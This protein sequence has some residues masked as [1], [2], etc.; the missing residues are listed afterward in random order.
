MPTLHEI[1]A[2]ISNTESK[3]AEDRVRHQYLAKLAEYTQVPTLLYASCF[4]I[5]E[6][7]SPL[8]QIDR[9][10][11]QLFMSALKDIQG[12]ELD[13]IIHS[14]GGSAEAT[15]QV[16]NYLRSKFER[17]RVIVPQS[18]MSAATM[19]AC[20]ADEIIMG[21]HSS[22]GPIDPQLI[23]GKFAVAAQSIIDEF[24]L[25]Q[26]QVNNPDNNPVLWVHKLQQYP[27]GLLI[28]C[29]NQIDLAKQL[30][31]EWLYQYMFGA[32]ADAGPKAGEIAAW[33]SDA[34]HFLS[35]GRSIGFQE[36]KRRGL[37]VRQLEDDQTLQEL[38]LSV[39]HC[40]VATFQ[41]GP[42]VKIVENH[43]GKG[44]YVHFEMNE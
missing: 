2:E 3:P 41:R 44:T 42:S 7:P 36:A 35:H 8:L 24:D 12:N 39:F 17:I 1:H 43:L 26:R 33:L 4:T 22:L 15:E 16:V 18:A 34:K 32:K 9:P 6:A 31:E 19:F 5:K 25:A 30:V 21:K 40:M 27:P 11:I 28:Q 20:S 13:I 38:V 29:Q 37:K 14:S 23:S 10:D